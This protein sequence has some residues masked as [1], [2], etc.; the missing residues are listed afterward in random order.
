MA[1]LLLAPTN[2]LDYSSKQPSF[3]MGSSG[4]DGPASLLGGIIAA[5]L[6]NEPISDVRTH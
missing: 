3:W 2:V 5:T 6:R 4:T 1:L